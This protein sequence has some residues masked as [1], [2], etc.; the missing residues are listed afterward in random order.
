MNSAVTVEKIN[1]WFSIGTQIF[2]AK[3]E[4]DAKEGSLEQSLTEEVQNKS[5]PPGNNAENL[6]LHREKTVGPNEGSD[7]KKYLSLQKYK[8][9]DLPISK[10]REELISL[11]ESNSVVII[12]GNT[13]SGKTT[14]VP[15]YILDHY[16]ENN[17]PCNIVV[18]QPRKIG[19]SSIARWVANERHCVLGSMVGYQV[20]LDK[21]A[22]E[23]TRLLY[24]T[25][26]V[27]LQKIISSKSLVEFSHIFIDE[28]HERSEDL[29]FLLLIVRKLLHSNSRYVK[30]VL[31][32]ATINC[33]EF[34]DYFGNPVRSHMN[35]ATV[36]E[37][38]GISHEIEDYYLDDLE[39][40]VSY[41]GNFLQSEELAISRAM[42][43]LA[44][45]LIQKFDDFETTDH[46]ASEDGFFTLPN[47]GSVLVFLPG[48]QE[49]NFMQDALSKLVRKR[50]QVHPLHSSVT[51][52]EQNGVFINPVPGY[53]KV[54]LSTNIAESSVTVPDV[55]YVIDFCLARQLVSDKET[56]YLTLQLV[57]AS[58]TNCNQRRGRAGRVAKGYCYRLVTKEF[59][60]DQIP[61]HVIPE[62]LR[63]PLSS[64]MLKVKLLDMG[65][66][67]A[68]LGSALSPPSLD[69]VEKTVLHLKTIGA[70]SVICKG[71]TDNQYDGDLT[72]LGRI[73]AH[74]PVDLYLGKMVVLGHVFGCLEECLII[75]A[76]LSLKNFFAMPFLQ[77]LDGYRSKLTF[78]AGSKSDTIA[79]VNAFKAWRTLQKNGEFRNPK[80]ELDWGRAHYIQIKRIKEVAEL[81]EDLK[82]RVAQFNMLTEDDKLSLSYEQTNKQKF[83]LQVVI[84][85]SFYPNY[86]TLTAIDEQL[87]AK[88]MSGCN[89][90]T[91]VM[92]RNIP[93]YGFLYYKQLQS[94]FRQ[95][96]QVKSIT[97]EHS[98]AY[99]EF[100]RNSVKSTTAHTEVSLAL[101][102]SPLHT[103]L[104]LFV[105]PIKEIDT[106]ADGR[107]ISGRVIADLQSNNVYPVAILASASDLPQL[108]PSPMFTVN[109]CEVM[110]VGHFWGYKSD[111]KSMQILMKLT[112]DINCQELQPLSS[113]PYPSMLCL[114]PFKEMDYVAY[115]RAKIIH[116]SANSVEVF[117]VDY[118]NMLLT[119][120]DC[121]RQ[122]PCHVLDHPFQA[123]E[124]QVCKIR[125]SAKSMILGNQWSVSARNRFITLVKGQ[126]L[127]ATLYSIV[128]DVMRVDLS[129]STDTGACSSIREILIKEGHAEHAE[130]SFLSKQSNESLMAVY[131][132]RNRGEVTN[133]SASMSMKQEKSLINKLL[134]TVPKDGPSSCTS[135]VLLHGPFSPF[136]IQ[137]SS[138]ISASLYKSVRLGKDSLNATGINECP[139]DTHQRMVVAGAVSI[140]FPGSLLLVN[141]TTMMPSIH[142]LPALICMLFTPLMELRTNME[143]TL[144]TGAL[145]GLG[146]NQKNNEPVYP[147]HDIEVVFD[148]QFDVSDIAEI[149]HLRCAI[150]KLVC[151]GPNGLLHMGPQRISHLQEM[152]CTAL[153]NLFS[154]PRKSVIPY[155]Y[156]KQ[157]KWNEVDQSIKM[158]LPQKDA[159]LKGGIVYQLHPLILLNS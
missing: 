91:T 73:L 3:N 140:N 81:F 45:D 111:E 155:Y 24:V 75:A 16:S 10:Y 71:A 32:S 51:L 112:S 34:A 43:S 26:G 103:Q 18:T 136:R 7:L 44:V 55:K 19:A 113:P 98:R 125:P 36:F 12:R 135:T 29:D 115:Y 60:R 123:Q 65:D 153:I 99:V 116:V 72:F 50:L 86:F 8:Y 156:E 145:C 107:V 25:T 100:Y 14:Q 49:I 102:M 104:E 118:G 154:K 27:L 74:L 13:G 121:L 124:F 108:P 157:H 41:N 92:L 37:V 95:C 28:V 93:Q 120:T 64:T 139:E 82:E 48:L 77:R 149:N 59:W 88:E 52:E 33:K 5:E 17:V 89:P 30:V 4:E 40:L 96:G 144:F 110:E 147:D 151:D 62:I 21:V 84:A 78:S 106:K 57:W 152:T 142:G 76:A 159:V 122:I 15:Q 143:G 94:L 137:L 146:W 68:V 6:Q 114:A 148:V 127:I 23:Y 87:A 11:I 67:R 79:V 109:I 46:S 129:I 80:D 105:H 132:E 56:N 39:H 53:R 117:F 83:I 54:I 31:M 20:G 90:A 138:M 9:P 126:T 131:E 69:D 119:R 38:E 133:N 1:E 101:R 58:K 158:E 97:Y 134:E 42:Y 35:P 150:N 130:E 47:R 2:S 70:L 128:H 22:S 63:C 61:D 66:P 141:E 85:G